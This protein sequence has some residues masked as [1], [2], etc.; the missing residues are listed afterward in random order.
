MLTLN[1][2]TKLRNFRDLHFS[3]KEDLEWAHDDCQML[4]GVLSV[5]ISAT[6]RFIINRE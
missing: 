4:R 6:K 2:T 3:L 1:M 5:I